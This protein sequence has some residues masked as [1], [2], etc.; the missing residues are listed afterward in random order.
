[1]NDIT[2]RLARENDAE[3]VEAVIEQWWRTDRRLERVQTIRTALHKEGHEIMVAE[4]EGGIVGVL[5][6]VL[7]PDVMFAGQ[8]SHIVFLL[9]DREHRRRGIGSRLV[10]KA[11]ERAKQQG[12]AEI[13]VD[14]KEKEAEQLFR[15]QGFEDDG[16]MLAHAL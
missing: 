5:H 10:E 6:L 15:K 12:A 1:M 4:S 11:M 7:H 13:H 8:Y 2:I 9:V 14:T 16:V 3:H